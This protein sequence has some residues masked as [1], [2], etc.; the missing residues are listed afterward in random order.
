M[1]AAESSGLSD[2][3]PEG[4]AKVG[5]DG[6]WGGAVAPPRPACEPPGSPLLLCMRFNVLQPPISQADNCY[7]LQCG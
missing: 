2:G 6:E 5:G 4:G 7:D 1:G 3:R